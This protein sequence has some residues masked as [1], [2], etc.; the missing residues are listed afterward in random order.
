MTAGDALSVVLEDARR[1]GFLGPESVERH[2]AH[3]E[4]WAEAIEADQAPS[5]FLDLGSGGGIPGLVLALRWPESV[6]VLLD[7]QLRRTAWLRTAVGRLGIAGRVSVAEGRAETLGHELLLRE[8][9]PL[10]VA[11]SFGA[12]PMTAELGSA[13]VVPG[14]VLSVSEPPGTGAHQRWPEDRLSLLGLRKPRQVVHGGS[15]FVILRKDSALRDGFPRGQNRLLR[16]P[17]W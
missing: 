9:F 13:F 1:L 3:A 6:V 12:P 10:V 2:I 17:V 14:G 8:Q 5:S 7:S 15:S 16:D 11:R 4:A